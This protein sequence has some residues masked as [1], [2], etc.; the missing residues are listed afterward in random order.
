MKSVEFIKPWNIYAP[1]DVAGFEAEQ[2][3]RLI[4]GKVAKAYEPD[5]KPKSAK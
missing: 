3:Q 1:G 4:D 2:A 5:A